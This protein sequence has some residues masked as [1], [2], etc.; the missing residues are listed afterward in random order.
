MPYKRS[1]GAFELQEMAKEHKDSPVFITDHNDERVL[2]PWLRELRFH[3]ALWVAGCILD[4]EI[5]EQEFQE[6]WKRT[7]H[8]LETKSRRPAA[9]PNTATFGGYR[10]KYRAAL[11]QI[12]G[13]PSK[14]RKRW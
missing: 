5:S 7:P 13:T 14:K 1:L 4:K 8:D 2:E 3:Q 6:Y 11:H 9:P 12:H 10:L